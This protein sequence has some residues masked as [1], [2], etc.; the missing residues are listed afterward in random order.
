[1]GY[2]ADDI[3][4]EA[5]LC[6]AAISAAYRERTESKLQKLGRATQRTLAPA[7]GNKSTSIMVQKDVSSLTILTRE[8]EPR[9]FPECAYEPPTPSV[10]DDV[11]MAGAARWEFLSL[12]LARVI[13]SILAPGD[14]GALACAHRAFALPV[15]EA[16]RALLRPFADA[17]APRRCRVS[18]AFCEPAW[19]AY[20]AAARYHHG[21]ARA[22]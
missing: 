5:R 14:M 11:K 12:D 19:R 15:E 2:D 13:I 20:K 7:A 22:G 10:D 17:D 9:S 1:M 18:N 6:Q 4:I 16:A 8:L 21:H 3:P